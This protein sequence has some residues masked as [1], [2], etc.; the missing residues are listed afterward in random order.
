MIN[1]ERVAVGAM[2]LIAVTL[3]AIYVYLAFPGA[4]GPVTAAWAQALGSIVAILVAAAVPWEIARRER[5][6][7]TREKSYR[8]RSLAF[9][10]LG[11]TR[12]L[13]N[14]LSLAHYRW[15]NYPLQYDD[16]DVTSA[17]VI[18]DGLSERLLD[19][20]VLGEASIPIQSAIVSVEAVR[21]GV[22]T[23]YAYHRYAGVWVDEQGEEHPLPE[24]ENVDQLFSD[25]IAA[26]NSARSALQETLRH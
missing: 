23:D 18:P 7:I 10:L 3:V 13:Q 26:V 16:D 21:E 6:R 8:A 17:L 24:P 19:L 4:L 20:H 9:V 22:N 11:S 15:R 14:N 1:S 12:A 2:V 5:E 25:A